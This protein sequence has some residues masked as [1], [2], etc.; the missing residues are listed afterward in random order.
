MASCCKGWPTPRIRL[1][2]WFHVGHFQ[3][4]VR[5]HMKRVG[6]DFVQMVLRVNRKFGEQLKFGKAMDANEFE[7]ISCNVEYF[8]D[9]RRLGWWWAICVAAAALV[10]LIAVR[11]EWF[12]FD[13]HIGGFLQQDGLEL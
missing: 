2:R 11:C 9:F 1:Q 13:H 8:T 6:I 3:V 10:L 5:A 4:M 12:H 7:L